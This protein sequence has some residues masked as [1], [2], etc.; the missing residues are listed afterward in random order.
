MDSLFHRK[1]SRIQNR[2]TSVSS[3]DLNDTSVPYDQI[4]SSP[5]TSPAKSAVNYRGPNHISA[6]LTNPTL[7]ATGTEFNKYALLRSRADRDR[8]RGL[9]NRPTS[10]ISEVTDLEADFVRSPTSPILHLHIH[11][12]QGNSDEFHFPRPETEEEIEALFDDIK[13]KRAIPE[14]PNLSLDQKWHMVYNDEHIRWKEREDHT[15]RHTI[16]GQAS[17]SSEGTPEWYIKKF[18]DKTINAK[19]AGSLLVSLRSK[20]MR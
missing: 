5:L 10:G 2:Q 20:E 12:R 4:G 15:R 14:M 6:P 18:L 11:A 3:Q 19:Q 9:A 8:D 13:R 7:T 17:S 1:R 16:T